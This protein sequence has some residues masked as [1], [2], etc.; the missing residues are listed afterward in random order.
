MPCKQELKLQGLTPLLKDAI[1][2]YS[3][4]IYH[5]LARKNT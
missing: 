2:S 5:T 3:S 1:K 4:Y